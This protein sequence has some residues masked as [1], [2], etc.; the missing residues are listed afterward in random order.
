M[1]EDPISSFPPGLPRPGSSASTPPPVPFS[2]LPMTRR[3]PSSRARRTAL[4]CI[5]R[6]GFHGRTSGMPPSPPSSI[7]NGTQTGSGASGHT[8]ISCIRRTDMIGGRGIGSRARPCMPSL[9]RMRWVWPWVPKEPSIR[10]STALNGS[11]RIPAR[12]KTCMA[13]PGTVRPS[14][15]WARPSSRRRT[16]KPGRSGR[17]P[18]PRPPRPSTP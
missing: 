6:T 4:R 18:S 3:I 15:P 14:W 9:F 12:T 5:R 13:S 17:M 7:C 11:S 2:G 8:E 16:E 1:P 10:P